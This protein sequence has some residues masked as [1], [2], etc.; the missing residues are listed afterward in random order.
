MMKKILIQPSGKNKITAE[1]KKIDNSIGYLSF[2]PVVLA[3]AVVSGSQNNLMPGL[4]VECKIE[5]G[6]CFISYYLNIIYGD[7]FFLIT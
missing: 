7:I 6:N 5:C 2:K 4:M 1:L 3:L